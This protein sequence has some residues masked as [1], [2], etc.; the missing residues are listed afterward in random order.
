M[1]AAVADYRPS[2]PSTAKIKKGG[3][4][5]TVG[6]VRN[7]D[8]LAEVGEA[9]TGKRPI[10]AGFSVETEGGEALAQCAR[11]KLF[12]KRVDLVVAN[13]AEGAFGRDDNQATIVTATELEPLSRLSKLALA[14]VVLDRV[15][16]LLESSVS[17]GT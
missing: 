1:A 17:I 13:Q 3:E 6:L 14:D 9:R 4:H 5:I 8:L 16:L 11:Q 7:P 10:L 2:D 12:Q 15:R